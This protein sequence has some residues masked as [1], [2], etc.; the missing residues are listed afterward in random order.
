M[1]VIDDDTILFRDGRTIYA[2]RHQRRLLSTLGRGSYA[3]VTD[4]FGGAACAAATS[5]RWST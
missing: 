1:M 2:Q 4:N 3:L 5:R